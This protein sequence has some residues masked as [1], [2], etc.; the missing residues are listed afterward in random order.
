MNIKEMRNKLGETQSEFAARYDI[1]MR[2]I[3]NWEA[4]IRKP[5]EYILNLLEQRIKADLINRRTLSIPQYDPGKKNLPQRSDFLDSVSWLKAVQ[6][7][8]GDNVVFALD[9]ALMCQGSFTGHTDE[10]VVWVYGDDALSDFN[11]VAILGNHINSHNVVEKNGLK[12]TD[13]NRTVCDALCNEAI[14]DFQG[15]TEAVSHYY[16][17]H[18]E[19]LDGISVPPEYQD[20]FEILV[21][22]AI[23]YYKE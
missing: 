6:S 7:H 1:P 5:P 14:L 21:E 10:Y 16:Y 3:Q 19:N 12:F 20:K 4:G 8:L 9:E 23:N 11:G 13:F 2:T 22:D 17:S 18:N 15:I